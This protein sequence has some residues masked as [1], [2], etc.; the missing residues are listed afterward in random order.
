MGKFSVIV[1]VY[2]VEK[3]ICECMES[4]IG[5]TEDDFEVIL[6]DDGST[7]LSSELCDTYA[8]LD[9]RIRVIHKENGGV[10]SA[11]M[12]GIKEAKTDYVIF[13]DSDD[14]L[15]YKCFEKMW[16]VLDKYNLD[17]VISNYRRIIFDK[18]YRNNFSI[19]PGIYEGDRLE[20]EI[21]PRML[22]DGGFQ[23]RGVSISRWGKIIRKSI[24]E[25]NLKYCNQR[26]SYSD[27]LNI[28]LPVLL[29]VKKIYLLD[30]PDA[31]YLYR[32][33]PFSIL[34]SY[35]PQ[36]Y[37]QIK[38]VYKNLFKC[39]Q[40]KKATFIRGQIHAD[41]LAAI[42]QCYKN[43][44]MS[45]NFQETIK[46]ISVLSRDN[47]LKKAVKIVKWNDYRLLNQIIIHCIMHWNFFHRNITTRL[48]YILK[49]ARVW[50]MRN[51]Y[52]K[53]YQD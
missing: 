44:L 17:M 42:V 11:W 37:E 5:Q 1:P 25:N 28:M 30:E 16:N 26:V 3:Y 49:R 31:D 45:N 40:E 51:H 13:V 8:Q 24:I 15:T 4:I 41:Y 38:L 48:L 21:Y 52:I 53:L 18:E 27:D 34:N 39:I 12:R 10:M 23:K 29:D 2:N 19:L 43:E 33:N 47:R 36:M 9:A 35:N 22:N 50:K 46:H 14:C 32:L 20:K 6:I 7:D